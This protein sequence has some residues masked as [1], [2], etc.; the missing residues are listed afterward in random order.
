M[1]RPAIECTLLRQCLTGGLLVFSDDVGGVALAAF[2]VAT[3]KV[4]ISLHV[5]DDGFDGRAVA[6]FAD[7]LA[8]RALLN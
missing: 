8:G 2:G 4:P 6:Q 7:G 1:L 3:A 5:A